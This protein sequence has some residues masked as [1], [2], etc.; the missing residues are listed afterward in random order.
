MKPPSKYSASTAAYYDAHAAEFCESTVSVD[1]RMLYGPFLTEIPAGGRILDAGCGSGRDSLAFARMGYQ[2]VAIDAS[3]EMVNATRRLTGL[4]ARQLPF[5]ALEFDNEF[6][7]IWACASL[8]HIA[9]QDLDAVLAR[10]TKALRPGGVFYLSFKYGDAERIESGR[11]FN[12]MNE[13][14]LE[15]VLANHSQLKV[16]RVWTTEDVRNER[17]GGQRWLNTI[18]RRSHEEAGE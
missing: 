4:E 15:A 18:V 10:L 13:T 16:V 5:D 1:M 2:V 8:L 14:L 17:R 12:D 9:R 7:G 3:S 6:D 11:F